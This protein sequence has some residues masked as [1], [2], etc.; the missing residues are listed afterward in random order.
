M[1]TIIKGYRVAQ[2][3]GENLYQI[4]LEEESFSKGDYADALQQA[5]LNTDRAILS[6][7]SR[8]SVE[9]SISLILV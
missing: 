2:Y 8:K 5:F 3:A 6:G 1:L 4:L 7:K 9:L